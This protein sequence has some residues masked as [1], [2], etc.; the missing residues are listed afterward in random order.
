L[1]LAGPGSGKTRVLTRRIAYLLRTENLR[2]WNILA[3]TFTNK[4][5]A[6][7]KKRVQTMLAGSDEAH[8]V[9][10]GTFHAIC[11][12][13]LRSEWEATPYKQDFLIYDTDDQ[14]SVV[15]QALVDLNINEKQYP[16]RTLLYA[17]SNAKNELILP[18][19]YQ[20]TDYMGEVVRRV[21]ARYQQLMLANNALDFDDLLLQTAVLLS[22]NDTLREKYQRRFITVLVDEFQDTNTAQYALVRLFGA[23]QDAVFAV[24]DED[25]SIYAFRGANYRNV[26]RFR[27]DYPDA[28]VVLLE[29]N[30]RSTQNILDTARAVIDKNAHR[31]PKALYT[32]KGKGARVIIQEAYDERREGEYIVEQ[33]LRARA[34]GYRYR[35]CA[36]MYRTNAQSR[37]LEAA[38]RLQAVPYTLIGGLAFFQRREVKDLVA[39]LRAIYNPNDRVSFERIVNTPKRGIGDRSVAQLWAWATKLNFTT[40]EALAHLAQGATSSINPRSAKAL[41]TFGRDLFRWREVAQA[42]KL[43]E[44]LEDIIYSIDFARYLHEISQTPAQLKE[45]QENVDELRAL[46]RM[47]DDADVT[48]GELLSE[49]ALMTDADRTEEHDAVRLLTLHAAKGLEYPIVF[50]AGVEDQY[51]PHVRSKEEGGDS[52]E[53]ERRLFYVG[54]TRAAERLYLTYAFKRLSYAGFEVRTPSPF[55]FDIPHHL[56]EGVPPSLR[57]NGANGYRAAT[58]W[59]APAPSSGLDRLRA[60]L[61][62]QRPPVPPPDEPQS[63]AR[64]PETYVPNPKFAGKIVPFP[65]GAVSKLKYKTGMIVMHATFGRGHVV[66]SALRD[67]DEV[68]TVAFEDKKHG[69]KEL[70]SSFANLQILT[71]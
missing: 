41:A 50:I 5:A 30:Y 44:T 34:E 12:R 1:V 7:M 6:E 17:I 38:F 52:I 4:A 61:A 48:L 51:L 55:L 40:T 42:G 24:G 59:D 22:E 56:L 36:V 53:E 49:W 29:E 58:T 32:S 33:V 23:P 9:Q 35:D 70:M 46:L 13:L 14:A 67:G 69:I 25:Q 57:L 11:A 45:R 66:Q 37:A 28:R 20:P 26:Q 43:L 16:P 65:G 71:Q 64:T 54:I 27:Q 21:Y 63:P 60:D 62:K 2:A 31:T 39:Y 68:V 19:Q 15:G 47:A 8:S 3:V 18:S 10:I